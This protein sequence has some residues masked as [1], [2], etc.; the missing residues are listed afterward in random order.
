MDDGNT[1]MDYL[2]QEKERGITINSA[3]IIALEVG[4]GDEANV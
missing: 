1:V 2:A 3:A 4:P